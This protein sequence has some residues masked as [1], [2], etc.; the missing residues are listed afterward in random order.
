MNSEFVITTKDE[1]ERMIVKAV[2]L[3][4]KSNEPSKHS[5]NDKRLNQ[6]EAAAFCGVSVQTIWRWRK[7]NMVPFEKLKGSS[8]IHFYESELIS[9]RQQNAK[10]LQLPR[11]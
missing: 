1:L 3:A 11:K 7:K 5:A 2:T 8:K 9:V 10:L 4:T 6:T